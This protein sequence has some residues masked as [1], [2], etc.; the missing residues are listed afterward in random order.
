MALCSRAEREPLLGRVAIFDARSG[1]MREVRYEREPGVARPGSIEERTAER[2][3]DGSTSIDSPA[4]A[5]ELA[6]DQPPMLIDVREPHEHSFVALP[7]STL[8]PLRDILA[9]VD[10]LDRDDLIRILT[11]PENSLVRQYTA[12]L[13]TEGVEVEFTDDAVTAIA[14][15]AALVNDRTENIGARRLHTVMEHVVEELSFTAP[16]RSGERVTV[17]AGY[18]RAALDDLVADEDLSKYIL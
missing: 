15:Y 10:P 3:L 12:L 9:G 18:V 11:E 7:G 2:E 6:G 13:R 8:I 14:E 17:D 16:E 5:A 4:L 1:G